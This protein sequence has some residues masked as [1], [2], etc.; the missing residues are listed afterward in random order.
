MYFD[1]ATTIWEFVFQTYMCIWEYLI[2]C[3]QIYFWGYNCL[4]EQ[5]LEEKNVKKIYGI[6]TERILYRSDITYWNKPE[7]YTNLKI[8][9]NNL[10]T[11]M[12]RSLRYIVQ[13]KQ[14]STKCCTKY[15]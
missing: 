4:Q 5:K 1:P 14:Q 11:E 13:K 12:E 3:I 15:V 10:C 2:G 8:W 9:G 7:Y 6:A